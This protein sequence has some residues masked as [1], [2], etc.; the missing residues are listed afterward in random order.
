MELRER[1]GKASG[2]LP[3][4][5][6]LD[7]PLTRPRG[8]HHPQRPALAVAIEGHPPA[9]P[10]ELKLDRFFGHQLINQLTVLVDERA[11]AIAEAAGFGL[12]ELH[13]P[14]I[15]SDQH[16]KRVT[17]GI[18]CQPPPFSFAFNHGHPGA[19]RIR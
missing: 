7:R 1:R 15:S 11:Q 19:N 6:A 3:A 2:C 18:P 13:R 14:A 17:A 9:L 12:T 8:E 4:P 10:F 16:G 5:A